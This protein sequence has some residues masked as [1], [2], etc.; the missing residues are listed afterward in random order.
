[1]IVCA[2]RFSRSELRAL[3]F[4]VPSGAVDTCMD[5]RTFR[6]SHPCPV[7]NSAPRSCLLS[8]RP[9]RPT[10]ASASSAPVPS[11]YTVFALSPFSTPLHLSPSSPISFAALPSPIRPC[12]VLPTHVLSSPGASAPSSSSASPLSAPSSHCS[13]RAGR[14]QQVGYWTSQ[15]A[16]LASPKAKGHAL[17][18]ALH[19]ARA[20]C[21]QRSSS[22]PRAYLTLATVVSHSGCPWT[23]P[24]LLLG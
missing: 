7:C 18:H 16:G 4:A 14:T 9:P 5:T 24:P 2:F 21:Q 12:T 17:V 23:R 6:T 11:C 10:G 15:L 19:R 20:F 13:R 8:A 22:E 3:N 1:M